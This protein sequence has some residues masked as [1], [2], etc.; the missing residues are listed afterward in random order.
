MQH[1]N[2]VKKR[3]AARQVEAMAKQKKGKVSEKIEE[4]LDLNKYRSVCT[5]YK[6]CSSLCLIAHIAI[7][8]K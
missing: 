6:D 5:Y 3:V 2:I 1:K 4:I 8:F 7:C